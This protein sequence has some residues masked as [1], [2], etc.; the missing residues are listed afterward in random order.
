MALMEVQAARPEMG[1]GYRHETEMTRPPT[2]YWQIRWSAVW[3]GAL[4]GFCAVLLIGLVGI[5]VGAH[6]IDPENRLVDLRKLSIAAMIFS[7]AGAFFSFVLAGWVS[8]RIAGFCHSEPSIL[9]G[10]MSWLV[11]VPI[12][13]LMATLGAANFF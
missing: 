1:D 7:V 4:A 11:A 3:V 2:R 12:L 8:G 5:A 13:M 6:L 10:A 9:H